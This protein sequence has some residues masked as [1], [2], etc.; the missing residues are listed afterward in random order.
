MSKFDERLNEI[1]PKP[2]VDD[3]LKNVAKNIQQTKKK[4]TTWYFLVTKRSHSVI[5]TYHYWTLRISNS[6][7]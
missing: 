4:I 5:F 1:S 2:T 7:V 6:E 3:K